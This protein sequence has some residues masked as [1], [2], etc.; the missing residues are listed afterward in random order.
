MNSCIVTKDWHWSQ[1]FVATKTKE[2]MEIKTVI[3]RIWLTC[4]TL[5]GKCSDLERH[6]PHQWFFAGVFSRHQAKSLST[7]M[8]ITH[9]QNRLTAPPYKIT[10]KIKRKSFTNTYLPHPK[11]TLKKKIEGNV[12]KILIIC[13][14]KK[15]LYAT[16]VKQ[17]A[18]IHTRFAW[19]PHTHTVE[20][21]SYFILW[22]GCRQ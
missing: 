21:I 17:N 3:Q 19:A 10:L 20:R 5:R 18:P 2:H 8:K 22:S 1:L 12:H 13:P 15:I 7:L 16:M 11:I 4:R 14:S 6:L 9:T